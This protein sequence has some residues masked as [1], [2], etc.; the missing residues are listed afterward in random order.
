LMSPKVTQEHLDARRGQILEAAFACFSRQGF[1]QTTIQDICHEAG[2]SPGAV[3]RYF[4]SK[5]EIIGAVCEFCR[6]SNI[7]V[8]EEARS[9][10]DT[11]G[12]LDELLKQ[13]IEEM[14]R[15]EAAVSLSLNVQWWAEALR[16]ADLKDMLR[17]SAID[18]WVEALAGIVRQGQ[19]RGEVNPDLDVESAGR[20]L[21]SMWFGLMLQRAIDPD[22]DLEGYVAVVK[23]VYSGTFGIR[24]Q[25]AKAP[26]TAV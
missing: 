15:P 23:S 3:Y 8:S 14:M 22:V 5:D 12:I 19:E 7:T 10:G 21:I 26:A 1:H 6:V 4:A 18:M 11:V 20:V 9:K 16:N 2:M 25:Q 24:G 13:G 17:E